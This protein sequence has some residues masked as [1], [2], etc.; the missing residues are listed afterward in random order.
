MKKPKNLKNCAEIGIDNLFKFQIY[1][2]TNLF[3]T[4][5]ISGPNLTTDTVSIE[6]IVGNDSTVNRSASQTALY[7]ARVLDVDK[8]NIP[9]MDKSGKDQHRKGLW[10]SPGLNL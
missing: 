8:G 5:D 9:V 2:G 4:S 6:Y 10:F 1:D 3:N 7:S